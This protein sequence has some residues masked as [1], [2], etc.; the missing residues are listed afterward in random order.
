MRKTIDENFYS[1]F[2]SAYIKTF[3]YTRKRKQKGRW[4]LYDNENKQKDNSTA[5]TTM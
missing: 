5:R 4:L 2:A 1:I 3:I